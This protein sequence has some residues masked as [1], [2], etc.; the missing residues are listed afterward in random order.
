[1]RAVWS[2]AS[3][4]LAVSF[5][6]PKSACAQQNTRVSSAEVHILPVRENVYM[7]VGAGG[8]VTVQAGEDGVLLVDTGSAPMSEKLLAAIKGLSDQPIRYII[9]TDM[10]PDDVGGNETIAGAGSTIAGGNVVGD[11]GASAGNQATVVAFQ[12]V[13]DRMSAPAGQQTPTPQGAWPTE[14]YTTPERKLFFNGEGIEMIHVPEAHTDGDTMVFF[15]RS[16]VISTGDIFVTTGYPFVDLERRGN[17]QG[18]IAGLN[19]IIELAIPE[20]LQEGGTLVVPG[21][22]RLCDVADVV[23][24]QEMV[25]II[26]DRV[27]DM[28]NKGMTLEQVK[29]A[30][31]TLD[32]DPRYGKDRGSWTTDMFVEAVYKS[33]SAK[34]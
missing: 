6:A 3:T 12:A 16:D 17:I 23:F 2:L 30:R 20:D 24:Y 34:K 10:D 21:R 4:L 19:K 13:L 28:V 5:L 15:R 7:L 9:D 25:T 33:L 22:G 18:V 8:N 14:T 32:Y 26:R 11:I 29:A 31:P 27:Q 1:M